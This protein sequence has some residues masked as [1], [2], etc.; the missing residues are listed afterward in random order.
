MEGFQL[1][2][3]GAHRLSCGGVVHH[4]EPMERGPSVRHSH[5]PFVG[6]DVGGAEYEKH[7]TG[8]PSSSTGHKVLLVVLV[9]LIIRVSVVHGFILLQACNG[10]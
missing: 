9:T 10:M 8:G 4:S 6:G 1:L 7:V 5:K 2:S 3:S